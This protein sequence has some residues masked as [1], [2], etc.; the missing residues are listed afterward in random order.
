MEFRDNEPIY[1]Q[2]VAFIGQNI[3]LGKWQA[4][5]KIPSVRDLAIELQVNLNT[6]LHAYEFLES[7]EV[8]YIKRGLGNF[9]TADAQEKVKAYRRERFLQQDLPVFFTNVYLLGISQEE[10]LRR[11]EQFTLNNNTLKPGQTDESK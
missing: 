10:L 1:L 5:Q 4:D 7:Q 11:Y 8:I 2:I 3:L 6:V 9:V